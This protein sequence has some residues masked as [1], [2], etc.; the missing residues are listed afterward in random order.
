[1]TTNGGTPLTL[2]GIKVIDAASL[3]AGPV[4]CTMLGDHGAE[5]TKV[6]HPSGDNLRLLGWS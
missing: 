6:E 4:I 5:V 2:E 3:F 1:M